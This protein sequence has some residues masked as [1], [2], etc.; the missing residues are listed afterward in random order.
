MPEPAAVETCRWARLTIR[1][2]Y[3]HWLDA[4]DRPWSC[5]CKSEPRTLDDPAECHH[6]PRWMPHRL[7]GRLPEA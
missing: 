5:L 6:C 7:D 4:E 1:T 3:P 2:P